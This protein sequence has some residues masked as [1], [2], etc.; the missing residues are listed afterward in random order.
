MDSI[1]HLHFSVY[2]TTKMIAKANFAGW[3]SQNMSLKYIF[4]VSLDTYFYISNLFTASLLI[5]LIRSRSDSI[6][7]TIDNLFT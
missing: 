6:G 2:K 4:S 3:T 7:R 5:A 1:S